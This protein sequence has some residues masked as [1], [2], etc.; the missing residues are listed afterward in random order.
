MQTQ[1][2]SAQETSAPTLEFTVPETGDTERV[3]LA[4]FPFR[5]G[6][7]E[8]LDL[9][10]PSQRVSR[11]HAL[12]EFRKGKYWIKDLGSTNG[13][14]L[15]GQRIKEAELSDGDLIRMADIELIYHAPSSGDEAA[16][17]ATLVMESGSATTGASTT[18]WLGELRRMQEMVL[19]VAV[20]CCFER[21]DDLERA[22]CFGFEI[23]LRE[24]KV[25][26]D[27]PRRQRLVG[28]ESGWAERWGDL[29]RL[30]AVTRYSVGNDEPYAVFVPIAPCE[31]GTAHLI[32][33]LDQLAEEL[34]PTWNLVLEIPASTVS[35]IPFFRRFLQEITSRSMSVAYGGFQ[36]GPSAIA[37]YREVRPDYL[38]LAASMIR[39]IGRSSGGQRQVKELVCAARELGCEAVATGVMDADDLAVVYE[40]G[41]RYAQGPHCGELVTRRRTAASTFTS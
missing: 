23:R 31:V 12:I 32:R 22:D 7:R 21:I 3:E 39:G 15:N 34:P 35:D 29:H 36:A 13:T 41:C 16:P 28:V 11:E 37:D 40:L 27:A 2:Y 1:V 10:L 9:P 17:T 6:R 4:C 18:Q 14:L 30:L 20:Q 5:V 25:L 26:G 38:K 19:H 24:N 8:D 33:S